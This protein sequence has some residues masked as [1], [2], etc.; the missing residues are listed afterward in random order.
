MN[1]SDVVAQVSRFGV[2]G[3]SAMFCHGVSLWFWADQVGLGAVFSNSLAF[4]AAF[5]IS[6]F[7]HYHWTFR[8][9]ASHVESMSKFFMV[10]L[11]GFF[12]NMLI[13][14]L[15]TAIYGLNHWWGFVLIVIT[16]PLMTYL[17]SRCWVFVA[18]AN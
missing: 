1:R 18:Q 9:E 12:L 7:G 15:V 14:Y 8:S 13:M 16:I 3:L 17:V 2:V 4:L 5:G 11:A 10:A 6:Y